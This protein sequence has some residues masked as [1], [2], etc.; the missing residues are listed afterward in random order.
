ME[1]DHL[2]TDNTLQSTPALRRLAASEH[3]VSDHVLCSRHGCGSYLSKQGGG[4]SDAVRNIVA[5]AHTI[6][7]KGYGKMITTTSPPLTFFFNRNPVLIT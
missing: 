3:T 1:T 7:I 5:H 4:Q 6:I 2:I